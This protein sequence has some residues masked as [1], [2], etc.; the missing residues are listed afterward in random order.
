M[1]IFV[2]QGEMFAHV[3]ERIQQRLEIPEKEFE[4]VTVI[5]LYTITF[6]WDVFY[7][8]H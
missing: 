7:R 8:K 6:C 3:K 5:Y 4:K 1:C 2:L